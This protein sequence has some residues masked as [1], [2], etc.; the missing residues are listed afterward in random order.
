MSL[1]P[2]FKLSLPLAALALLIALAAWPGVRPQTAEATVNSLTANSLVGDT[3]LSITVA[4]T[5]GAGN[6]VVT[7]TSGGGDETF[8]FSSCSIAS[9]TVADVTAGN[10]TNSLTFNTAGVAGSYSLVLTMAL[11]CTDIESITVTADDADAGSRSLTVFCVPD[12]NDPQVIVSKDSDSGF[13]ADFNWDAS[14]GDCVVDAEGVVELDDDGSF[15]LDDN[16]QA[17]F[18]CES[19]V[20]LVVGEV[21]DGDFDG[22]SGCSESSEG[23]EDI[24][25]DTVTFDISE[26]EPG[27]TVSCTWHN[28]DFVP[29][30]VV[31]PVTSVQVAAANIVGCGGTT[32]VQVTVRNASGGPAPA[33]TSVTASSSAGGTFQPS[34]TLTGNF[35]FSFATFLYQ[36]PVNFNGVATITV[37]TNNNV[38]GVVNIQV[39]CSTAPAPA[40]TAPLRPPSAG[41]GGLIGGDGSGGGGFGPYLPS[42]FA[43]SIAAAVLGGTLM[44]RRREAPVEPVASVSAQ[45]VSRQARDSSG[46]GFAILASLA[47]T[48]IALF[49]RS[50]R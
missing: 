23:V 34:A 12:D 2:S 38:T 41:S 15:E 30:V 32:A 39:A 49:L 25:G 21:N 28:E 36:A 5:A 22:I 42:A 43:A 20:T 40:P 10:G 7:T 35:P 1:R 4:G 8:T 17:E 48:G 16:D 19:G 33:G 14:G 47:L 31:G 3:S 18:W 26:L 24:S 29:T 45:P 46:A 11:N 9:C 44:S 6:L 37:R 50:R 13:D 27:D